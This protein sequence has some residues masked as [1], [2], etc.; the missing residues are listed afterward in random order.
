MFSRAEGVVRAVDGVSFFLNRGETLGLVGESGC[1]KTTLGKLIIRLLK[2]TGGEVIFDGEKIFDLRGKKLR[3]ER[4]K[5][6]LIFQDPYGSL[7]P[8]MTIKNTIG[9][10]LSI[11]K[12]ARGKEKIRRVSELLELVGLKSSDMNRYPH[13]FSGGQRQR[14]VIA[15]A[16]T[17]NPDLIIADEPVSALDMSVQS[18]IL[19]LL[20]DLQ[21]QFHLSYIFISHDLNVVRSIS[22]RVAVMYLGKILEMSTSQDIY[23]NPLHPYTRAL[24]SAAPLPDPEAA[25]KPISLL[26]DVSEFH[27][28]SSGCRF[29][30]RCQEVMPE[31][32]KI[33]PGLKNMGGGHLAACHLKY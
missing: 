26:G 21:K 15:R 13:E 6:Q 11:H 14:I 24:L 16:L 20:L 3:R 19:N 30:P 2:A 25:R 22:D 17:L 18:Q 23:Q 7:N 1:G 33:E 10:P 29:Y 8:R 31:C 28:L 32:R 12:L 27:N 5:M 9:E 4:R